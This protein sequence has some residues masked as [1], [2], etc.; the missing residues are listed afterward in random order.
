LGSARTV[1]KHGAPD[2]R[3]ESGKDDLSDVDRYKQ[4]HRDDLIVTLVGVHASLGG[5]HEPVDLAMEPPC[6]ARWA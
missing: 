2:A 5:K 4:R 3:D 6:S 1:R